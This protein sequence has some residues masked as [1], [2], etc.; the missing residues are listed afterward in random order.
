MSLG[1]YGEKKEIT[2]LPMVGAGNDVENN[3]LHSKNDKWGAAGKSLNKRYLMAAI[4]KIL[5]SKAEECLAKIR[6]VNL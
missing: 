1:Q 4:I 5:K 2:G 3:P 6:V